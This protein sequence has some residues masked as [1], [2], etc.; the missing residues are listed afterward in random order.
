MKVQ[1]SPQCAV[2]AALLMALL[3]VSVM[4]ADFYGTTR[5]EGTNVWIRWTNLPAAV[6]VQHTDDMTNWSNALVLSRLDGRG[7]D[8]FEYRAV[9]A[10]NVLM[11]RLR[12]IAP[13]TVTNMGF[14]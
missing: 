3:A 8:W 11:Y 5:V 2:C 12:Q 9:S 6:V 14:Q 7:L 1:P 4:A 10:S 13:V